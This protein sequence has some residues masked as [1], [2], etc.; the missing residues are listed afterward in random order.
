MVKEAAAVTA[1]LGNVAID[2]ADETGIYSG[3]GTI[4]AAAGASAKAAIGAAVTRNT[5]VATARA[6]VDGAEPN[7]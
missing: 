6:R 7:A 5:I 4:A 3:A 1:A 2:A